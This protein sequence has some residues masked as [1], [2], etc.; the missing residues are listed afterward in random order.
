M[1]RLEWAQPS[2]LAVLYLTSIH[3]PSQSSNQMADASFPLRFRFAPSSVGS[4]RGLGTHRLGTQSLVGSRDRNIL[5]NLYPHSN[6]H[7]IGASH[8]NKRSSGDLQCRRI[9]DASIFARLERVCEECYNLY[10]DDE[11]LG[12]CRYFH[13]TLFYAY[14]EIV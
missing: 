1:P 3:I 11:V 4:N 13:N 6:D 10:K 12:L 8:I 9:H 2:L 5:S 7:L 14:F